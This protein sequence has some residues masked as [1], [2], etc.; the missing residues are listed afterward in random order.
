MTRTY[1]V[2]I[3]EHCVDIADL[4]AGLDGLRVAHIG[5][6]HIP[7]PIA[8]LQQVNALL[9]Q[10]QP[11]LLVS[12]G[13]LVDHPHW[14]SA[15]RRMLPVLF[16][17]LR[18]QMGIYG[19]LGNHDSPEVGQYLESIGMQMLLNR[20]VQVSRNGHTLNLCGIY[21]KRR[22]KPA[23]IAGCAAALL[24]PTGPTIVLAHYPSMIWHVPQE[25]V[26]LMLSG[27]TH[28]GQW[29]FGRLGCVWTH[30]DLPRHMAWGLHKVGPS[31]LYVTAGL[32]ESGPIPVRFNCPPEIAVLTLRRAHRTGTEQCASE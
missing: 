22:V 27:H 7:K 4:P 17:G 5:D 23:G 18:P 15:T 9:H 3:A 32:G 16:D 1:P 2:S 28:A 13:D 6:L 11:D 14:M 29:R 8:F 30:D 31:Y 12:T 10:I 24:P 19:T 21:G 25:R 20:C 26:N